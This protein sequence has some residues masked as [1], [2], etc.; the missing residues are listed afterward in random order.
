MTNDVRLERDGFKVYGSSGRLIYSI[1]QD[2]IEIKKWNQN[3]E[4]FEELDLDDYDYRLDE[5]YYPTF[6]ERDI[7]G[8][9]HREQHCDN[10][11]TL[12]TNWV[13]SNGKRIRS[14][15]DLLNS[16]FNK[17][18][19]EDCCPYCPYKD[20]CSGGVTGGPNGPIYPYCA[21]CDIHEKLNKE[22]F[23]DDQ[24][25]EMFKNEE[26]KEMNKVLEL[27]YERRINKLGEFYKELK[28][29]EYNELAVVKEFNEVVEDYN[30][31]MKELRGKYRTEEDNSL[32]HKTGYDEY[33]YVLSYEVG[34][35]IKTSLN[36]RYEEDKKALLKEK[37]TI[38]AVLSLSEDKDYQVEVLKNYGIL[39]KKGMM[40]EDDE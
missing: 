29:Q 30:N 38:A 24:L 13:T 25:R 6:G 26:E 8:N 32:I 17:L 10:M 40:V 7:Y 9:L 12:D 16:Q 22:A 33:P 3:A 27:Y 4:N 35:D 34:D 11:V 37:E 20:E 18:E 15:I 31:K 2:G 14:W 23:F 39:D 28:E 5:M 36:K 1:T 19:G 21:D